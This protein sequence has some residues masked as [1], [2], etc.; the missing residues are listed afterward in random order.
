MLSVLNTSLSTSLSGSEFA[1]NTMDPHLE[2]EKQ[3][4]LSEQQ[5]EAGEGGGGGAS[6]IFTVP[7]A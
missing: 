6:V 5:R 1:L 7:E 3:E 2:R 4:R